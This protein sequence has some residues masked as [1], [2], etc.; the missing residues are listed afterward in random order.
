[1]AAEGSSNLQIH[2]LT[3]LLHRA[4]HNRSFCSLTLL[5]HRPGPAV[6]G[7]DRFALFIQPAQALFLPLRLHRPLQVHAGD[8]IAEP[9]ARQDQGIVRAAVAQQPA[10]RGILLGIIDEPL[11]FLPAH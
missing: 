9:A 6:G 8:P 2:C 5:G 4:V 3:V 1:M 10:D 11:E 7:V